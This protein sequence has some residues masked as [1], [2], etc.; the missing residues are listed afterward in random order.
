MMGWCLLLLMPRATGGCCP[1]QPAPHTPLRL[2]ARCFRVAIRNPRVVRTRCEANLRVSTA[3][4][5]HRCYIVSGA[6]SGAFSANVFTHASQFNR[7]I[8][9]QS[10]QCF[11][12]KKNA[13]RFTLSIPA[14][15]SFYLF[16]ALF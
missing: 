9:S 7:S 1:P 15:A 14:Y 12:K 6:S 8:M 3:K 5:D 11:G 4:E 2:R 16:R 10:V 13:V